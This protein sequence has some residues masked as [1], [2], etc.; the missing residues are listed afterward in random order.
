MAE[1]LTT[2]ANLHLWL[3]ADVSA[4]NDPQLTMLINQVSQAILRY[5]A[6]DTFLLTTF[7]EQYDGTGK[8]TQTLTHY[9]V[10]DVQSV[11]V[12][13]TPVPAATPGAWPQTGFA[14][15]QN[16]PVPPGS[17]QRLLSSGYCFYEGQQ[18]VWV[19]YRAGYAIMAEQQAVVPSN[20][21]GSYTVTLNQPYG[22]WARDEGVKYASNGAALTKVAAA[23]AIGQ[24]TCSALGVYGF[25]ASDN[26]TNLLFSYSYVPADIAQCCNELVG[27]RFKYAS[28]IGQR[29][30]S[31]NG[32]ET[33]GYD[34]SAMPL[35]IAAILDQ[36]KTG[37]DV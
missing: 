2:L 34:L 26:A 3:G 12:N 14:I 18:N 11:A 37:F 6:Q 30:Q 24:Y 1:Q 15:S 8:T 9:P 28:R 19:T 32:Q 27:E 16:S 4:N 23:P 35:Y 5:I 25:N 36:Y 33:A 31:V 20:P 7:V 17:H 21:A 10:I 13:G 22:P 29:S